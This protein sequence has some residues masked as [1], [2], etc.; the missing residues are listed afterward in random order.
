MIKKGIKNNN[1][2]NAKNAWIIKDIGVTAS[3][4]ALSAVRLKLADIACDEKNEP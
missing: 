1:A 4:S 2:I 3:I